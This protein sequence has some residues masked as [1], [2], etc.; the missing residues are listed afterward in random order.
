MLND[1]LND[2]PKEV[3]NI[4]SWLTGSGNVVSAEGCFTFQR[5]CEEGVQHSV[6]EYGIVDVASKDSGQSF[7][8]C[9]D[10]FVDSDHNL[11]MMYS[12]L[13]WIMNMY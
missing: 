1:F 8:V 3:L 12:A 2:Q 10:E 9:E 11:I 13:S 7:K 6:I 5:I 4:R